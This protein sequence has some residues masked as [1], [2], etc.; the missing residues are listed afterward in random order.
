MNKTKTIGLIIILLIFGVYAAKTFVAHQKKLE[1][2]KEATFSKVKASAYW[3]CPMHP[4]IHS[5][6]PGECPI[7]HMQLVQVKEQKEVLQKN[8]Q[9]SQ[10][11]EVQITEDQIGLV[12]IHKLKVEKMSLVVQL[13]VSGRLISSSTV[14]FQIYESDIRTIKIGTSFIR[15]N[16]HKCR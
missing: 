8:E 14:A 6:K 5:D 15:G 12:G 13:P 3:T 10:R 4:Q 7:C 16:D 9:K 11:S 2:K 1:I